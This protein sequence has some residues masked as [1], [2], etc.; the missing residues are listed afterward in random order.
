ML[1]DAHRAVADPPGVISEV[2][3][4]QQLVE[5]RDRLDLR[6]RDQVVAAEP[7]AFTFDAALLMRALNTGVAVERLE[8]VMRPERHPARGLGAV[9]PNST[10]DTAALRSQCL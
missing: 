4:D 8:A 1:P 3:A 7:A 10:R 9:R 5:F 2:V 6:D